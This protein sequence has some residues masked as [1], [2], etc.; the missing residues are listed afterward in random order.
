M[1][2][3]KHFT[4]NYYR[5]TWSW[6][7]YEELWEIIHLGCITREVLLPCRSMV[8]IAGK[9]EVQNMIFPGFKWEIVGILFHQ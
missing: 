1:L 3:Q 7:Y 4:W 5:I 2:K 8:C 9:A 6:D